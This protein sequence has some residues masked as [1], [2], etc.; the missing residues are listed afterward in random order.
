MILTLFYTGITWPWVVATVVSVITNMDIFGTV[1]NHTMD[2]LND[3]MKGHEVNQELSLRIRR[4]VH[5]SYK[6][7][8]A[9]HQH[10]AINWL[11]NGLKGELAMESGVDMVC[12]KVWFLRSLPEEMV[13]ELADEFKGALFSPGEVIMDAESLSVIMRGSCVRKGR[14]LARDA[15]F[16]EDMI[17]A[18]EHLKDPSCPRTLTFLEVQRLHRDNL[19]YACAKFPLLDEKLRRAQLKLA[20]WRGFIREAEKQRDQIQKKWKCEQVGGKL[21][22]C[23]KC[24][25]IL[26]GPARCQELE[27]DCEP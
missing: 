1:F 11:S 25:Q 9:K 24:S 22:Q 6:I 7:Q 16:G 12:A 18:S 10:T 5:E 2:D 15:V 20:L 13:I 23:S 3:V 4:H 19:L 14:M 8:A 27:L 21:F 26:Q 17:L